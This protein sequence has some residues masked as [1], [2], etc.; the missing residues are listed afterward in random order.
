[1]PCVHHL[2][3]PSPSSDTESGVDRG[4]SPVD[5]VVSVTLQDLLSGLSCSIGSSSSVAEGRVGAA[6]AGTWLL[7]V[8]STSS[9]PVCSGLTLPSSAADEPDT[10][11]GAPGSGEAGCLALLALLKL[12]APPGL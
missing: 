7:V 11:L 2:I 1:M 12:A 10:M 5:D 9:G 6:S 4:M 8:G 3:I